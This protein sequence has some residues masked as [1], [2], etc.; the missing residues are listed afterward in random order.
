MPWFPNPNGGAPIQ[1]DTNPNPA[2]GS[3]GYYSDPGYSG[4]APSGASSSGGS[5]ASPGSPAPTGQTGANIAAGQ[6]LLQ[7][8][9]NA[10][11]QAYLNARLQ[12]DTDQEAYQK[13]AQ[14]AATAIAQAGVTGTFNGQPTQAAIKQAADIAQQQASTMVSY[15]QQF[16]TWGVPQA[17]QQTLA[18]QQQQ[19]SQAQQAA[20]LTGWYT[21]YTYTP[22]TTPAGTSPTLGM[23]PMSPMPYTA[24]GAGGAPGT[25]GAASSL[26]QDAYV[27]ARTAQLQQVASMSPQQAQQTAQSEWLQGLAQS[28][29]VAY[30]MP[31]GLAAPAAQAAPAAMSAPQNMQ[32]SYWPGQGLAA[33]APQAAMSAPQNME[34]GYRTQL[35]GGGGYGGQMQMQDATGAQPSAPSFTQQQYIA[36]RV[37]QLVGMGYGQDQASQT[38][39]SEWNQGYAQSGN[40]AGG[41]PSGLSVA[42]STT[43]ATAGQPPP[44]QAQGSTTYGAPPGYQQ[45]QP[46]Q[47]LA[48]QQQQWSQGFQEQQQQQQTAQNYLN[49]LSQLR[50]PADYAQYQKVLGATPGGMQSL[51][52]AAAG[53][54]VPGGGATT[55]VQPQ[56]VTLQSFL[57]QATG[58]QFSGTP[59]GSQQQSPDQA[60]LN[61]LVAPNQMAPQTWNALTNSQQQLLL[62]QWQ[63]Q[64]Y[65]QQDAQ[66][67]F[68]QSLPKYGSS[69]PQTGSFRLQ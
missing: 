37:Q 69:S 46:I 60:A 15:A 8:A 52:A 48:G 6:L 41:L 14:A 35:P 40:V 21:P 42:A 51:V 49:L 12:L 36:A 56:G 45:G 20:Q 57:N 55:G 13:A 58:G 53:Q 34:M 54:Y 67:L 59:T 18:A 30:G 27:Q 1:A 25:P 10:A 28:G 3:L 19:F 62:G 26:T 7:Q 24:G 9:Q 39:Q 61:S 64:G 17:G 2:G 47:T 68:N 29:N 5:P 38:A 16:G 23:Q 22:P 50:G 33:P 4:P 65:T 66:N 43:P 32:M 44:G 11:N 63:N 31:P